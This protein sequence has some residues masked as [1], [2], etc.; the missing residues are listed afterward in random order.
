[1]PT[2]NS[3]NPPADPGPPK[4]S[5]RVLVIDD[6][7]QILEATRDSLAFFGHRI[8]V[9]SGGKRGLEIFYEAI[10]KSEPYDVVITDLGMPDMDGCQVAH[11]IKAESAET[12]VVILSG[13]GAELGGPGAMPRYVDAVVNKPARIKELND[14]LLELS[15]PK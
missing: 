9:A 7:E 3:P 2:P 1:M 8:R 5:L 4:R 15:R 10:L 12:P 6:D 14:L 11:Q 13:R